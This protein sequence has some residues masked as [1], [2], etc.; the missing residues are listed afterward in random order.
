MI[1]MNLSSESVGKSKEDYL[2]AI[3][4]IKER[5]GYV[6]STDVADQ[7]GVTKPSVSY[8]TRHLKEDGF[9]TSDHA[10]MLVLTDSGR[11]IAERIY[12][13]HRILTKLFIE[14]GVSDEQAAI[15]ACKTEHDL[16]DET[17]DAIC[18]HCESGRK[19]LDEK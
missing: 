3:L 15:D 9:I 11:E 8:A 7:L 12:R 17:F 16:S 2:E 1:V 4:I 18:R 14:L 13:R 5:Q 10:G 6:R 19:L